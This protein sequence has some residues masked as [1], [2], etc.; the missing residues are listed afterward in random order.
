VWNLKEELGEITSIYCDAAAPVVWQA[1]K[2]EFREPYNEQYIK[3]T[4]ANCRKLNTRIENRMLV[5]PVSFEVDGAKMLQNAKYLLE[6][7]DV[8]G[9]S[10]VAIHPKFTKLL[11]ALH[12]AC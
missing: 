7:K 10:L 12:T 1:L 2:K 9:S 6:E 11:T 8:D 4:I 3:E 5:V